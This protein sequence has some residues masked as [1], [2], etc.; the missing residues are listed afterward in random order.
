MQATDDRMNVWCYSSSALCIA[1]IISTHIH[2]CKFH[3]YFPLLISLNSVFLN[4]V[5]SF[6]KSIICH[7]HR[8]ENVTLVIND[9][10]N[11]SVDIGNFIV[12]CFR[13][14]E[15]IIHLFPQ[16]VVMF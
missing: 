12:I 16:M 4:L 6:P 14:I 3:I 9:I 11:D 8:H 2:I 15:V 1:L 5:M 13:A 10:I 7:I